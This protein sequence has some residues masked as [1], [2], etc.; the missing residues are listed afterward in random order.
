MLVISIVGMPG[1][2]KTTVAKII[3]QEFNAYMYSSGDVIRDEIKRR[4]LRYTK[5]ND[6]KVS[7]WFHNGRENLIVKRVV[8]KIKKSKKDIVVVEGLITESE[9]K[10][11]EKL[12]DVVLI[13]VKAPARIRHKRIMERKRF[14]SQT[15]REYILK[16][17]RREKSMGIEKLIKHAKYTINNNSSEKELRK[18]VVEVVN[19]ILEQRAKKV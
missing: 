14:G 3:K 19:K 12:F 5:E 9:E 10:Y 2:G 16:R 17:D 4:G 13:S 7:E 11:L 6:K 1:S 15:S 18:K 8:S